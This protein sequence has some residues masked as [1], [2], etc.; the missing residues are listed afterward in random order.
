MRAHILYKFSSF[1][2]IPF[3]LL[4]C[5]L[6]DCVILYKL[7]L[8]LKYILMQLH[9]II[10]VI[11]YYDWMYFLPPPACFLFFP[12]VILFI[13]TTLLLFLVLIGIFLVFHFSYFIF[14]FSKTILFL[15]LYIITMRS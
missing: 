4:G 1:K 10:N 2:L 15:L 5:D 8:A 3:Y 14:M 11:I 7:I 9:I 12:P 6:A 13:V